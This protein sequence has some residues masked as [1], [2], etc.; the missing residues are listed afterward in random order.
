MRAERV[1][2]R[3]RS[4]GIIQSSRNMG[5]RLRR[6]NERASALGVRLRRHGE[7]SAGWHSKWDDLARLG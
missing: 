2:W 4:H 7:E 5:E 3:G 1:Q 6:M